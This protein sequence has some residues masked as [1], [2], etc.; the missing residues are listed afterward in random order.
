ME[1]E[2]K[3]SSSHAGFTFEDSGANMPASGCYRKEESWKHR[4]RSASSMAYHK[5]EKQ[6]SETGNPNKEDYVSLKA[7]VS[8]LENRESRLEHGVVPVV[9][10]DED[11]GVETSSVCKPKLHQYSNIFLI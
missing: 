9:K 10:K 3:T 4:L 1:D 2:D 5:P 6:A 7:G 11:N 8:D